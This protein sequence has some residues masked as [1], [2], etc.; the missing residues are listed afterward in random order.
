MKVFFEGIQRLD[1][2]TR[3]GD[4]IQ[5]YSLHIAYPDENVIGRKTDKKFLSDDAFKNLGLTLDQLAP[6]TLHDV[7]METNLNG[8]V[9]AIMPIKV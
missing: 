8:K 7:E 1:F 4:H 9:I 2:D 6:L 3:E 5:G